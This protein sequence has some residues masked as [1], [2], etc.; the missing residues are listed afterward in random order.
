MRSVMRVGLIGYGYWGPHLLRNF[1]DLPSCQILSCADIKPAT[2]ALLRR[3]YPH[4]TITSNYHEILSNPDIDGVIIATPVSTHFSIACEALTVGKDVLL[5][6]PM[7]DRLKDA[8][9]LVRLAKK[10]KRLLMVDHTFVYTPAVRYIKGV[11]QEKRLGRLLYVDSVRISLGLFQTDVNVIFDLAC[12]DFA[13]M[14]YLLGRLPISLS[15]TGLRIDG[16]HQEPHAYVLAHYPNLLF[17]L[18]ISWLSP[19]KVRTM[20][21]SGSQKML[22]YNDVEPHEKIRIYDKGVVI[23]QNSQK[24][25]QAR[26]GYR[27]GDLLIPQLE[28]KEGLANV[29]QDFIKRSMRRGSSLTYGE[30]G[31]RVVRILAAATQSLRHD[32]KTIKI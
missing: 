28:I 11:L 21:F 29:A 27:S 1:L 9:H 6:K 12:H 2:L 32:G 25:Y 19:V 5:E 15:A 16:S 31:A 7:T 3:R 14:D 13:I 26:F 30:D 18:H 22:V 8:D 24:I 17:H 10:H 4:L 20:T 23:E